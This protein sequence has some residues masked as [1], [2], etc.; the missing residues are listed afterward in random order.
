MSII[1]GDKVSFDCSI[2]WAWFKDCKYANSPKHNNRK[3]KRHRS[4]DRDASWTYD[5]HREQFVYGYKVHIAIDS[6]SGLPVMLTVTK[7]GHGENRT[8]PFFVK[9]LIKVGLNVKKFIADA[10]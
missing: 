6:F 5:N 10:A 3:C 7:A 2:I 1:K 8:V 9:M 4:R